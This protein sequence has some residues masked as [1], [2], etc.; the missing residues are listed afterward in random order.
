M[1]QRVVLH[2][3]L[4]KSGTSYLQRRLFANQDLLADR[5]VLVPGARW[6]DQVLAVSDVLGRRQ[7]AG[8]SAGRWAGLVEAVAAHPG[9]AVVSMEFLGPAT[10]ERIAAVHASFPGTRVEAVVTLRDLGRGVP[11]MWQEALQNGGT[12]PWPTYVGLLAGRRKPAQA[13]W[14]QQGMARIVGNWTAALGTD[15]VTLVTVPPAGADPDL[16]WQRFCTATGVDGAGATD[17]PPVNTSLDAASATVL[18]ELNQRLAEDALTTREYHTAVKFGLA[19]RAMAGRGGA[20]IGFDPPPWLVERSAEIVA[21]LE[22]SGARVV[23]E[24]TD[25]VPARV[26]G[27]DPAQVRP[28]EAL[29][30][31]V[32]ALRAVTLRRAGHVRTRGREPAP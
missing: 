18:L 10:P 28:E 23:G 32:D 17:V 30:A 3:G 29:A 4:M 24:L 26:P 25:L 19:K 21:R 31:A 11:A 22:G 2:V 1:A 27:V 9:A 15:A 14:R 16:L 13:F 5:G 8:A 7:A 6:R 20:P 12:V